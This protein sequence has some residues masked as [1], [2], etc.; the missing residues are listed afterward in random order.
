LSLHLSSYSDKAFPGIRDKRPAQ[1]L[2]I[3]CVV[4]DLYNLRALYLHSVDSYSKTVEL[5]KSSRVRQTELARRTGLTPTAI[6]RWLNG[7]VTSIRPSN[8]EAVATALGKL[9]IWKNNGR[10][11]CEF[12]DVPESAS[13]EF[14]Q[15]IARGLLH[16]IFELERKIENLKVSPNG[17]S[18][19]KIDWYV[20]FSGWM[21]LQFDLD[22]GTEKISY[23]V[24]NIYDGTAYKWIDVLGYMKRD[25]LNIDLLS[26]LEPS[27]R[28][29]SIQRSRELEDLYLKMKSP[30]IEVDRIW[31]FRHAEGHYVPLFC[32]TRA[33]LET[34][35]AK[36]WCI[37]LPPLTN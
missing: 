23:P 3:S 30:I 4:I 15:D 31:K 13:G 36:H 6:N 32:H 8:V 9:V 17:D 7:R 5:I 18:V 16:R 37:P 28:D 26:L 1:N 11:E 33:N 10:S 19:S 14:D 29:A 25:L 2:Y 12:R 34:K 20:G 27:D 21:Q 22:V 35:I 24:R